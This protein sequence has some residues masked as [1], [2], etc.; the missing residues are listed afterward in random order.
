M[1]KKKES[2]VIHKNIVDKVK[3]AEDLSKEMSESIAKGGDD[4]K[5]VK[6]QQKAYVKFSKNLQQEIKQAR[7]F[8]P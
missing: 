1:V 2:R 4:E 3:V 7:T 5:L 8:M 6:R